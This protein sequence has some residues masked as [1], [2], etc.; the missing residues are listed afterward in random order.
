MGDYWLIE[1]D[2]YGSYVVFHCLSSELPYVMVL[3]FHSGA[4]EDN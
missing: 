4:V 2:D 1:G 3:N